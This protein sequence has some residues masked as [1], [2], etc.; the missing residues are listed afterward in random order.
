[1]PSPYLG[2]SANVAFPAAGTITAVANTNPMI[3]TVSGTL[4]AQM[5]AVATAEP[6]STFPVDVEGVQ[7]CTAANGL[8]QATVT[9][10]SSF[11][12]PAAGNAPYATGGTVEYIFPQSFNT[13]TGGDNRSSASVNVPSNALGDRTLDLYTKTGAYRLVEIVT[14]QASEDNNTLWAQQTSVTNAWTLPTVSPAW[15]VPGILTNDVVDASLTCTGLAGT[16]GGATLA[17]FSILFTVEPPGVA[18]TGYSKFGASNQGV[19]PSA[20]AIFP[21]QLRSNQTIF[22]S[23]N[24]FFSPGFFAIGSSGTSFSLQGDFTFTAYVWRP[25]GVPQ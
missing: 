24:L 8:W 12:I 7:G 4:P 13:P 25:T 9:G 16:V 6:G 20:T 18:P 21:M 17:L 11:S 1:M 14:F 19:T 22:G 2:I 10:P 3:V 5:T 15:E 23:G